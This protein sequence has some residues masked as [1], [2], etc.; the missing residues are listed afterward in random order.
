MKK[1][2]VFLRGRGIKHG[3]AVMG[4][5]ALAFLAITCASQAG[6]D[7]MNRGTEAL[8]EKDWDR[9]IEEYTEA[10]SLKTGNAVLDAMA[11]NSRGTAYAQKG[12]YDKAIADFDWL[13]KKEP[14]TGFYY[15]LRGQAHHREGDYD[16]AIADYEAAARLD[17]DIA[18]DESVKNNL[19]L[20]H[21]RQPLPPPQNQ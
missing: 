14:A 5:A 11:Y 7:A 15:L 3:I 17:P 4:I 18:E 9:A 2:L 10:I 21:W 19:D 12:D 8:Q 13:I 16:R 1:G 20:A 6:M